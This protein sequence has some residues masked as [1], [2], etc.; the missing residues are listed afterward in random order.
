[1]PLDWLGSI[2]VPTA[3]ILISSGI[4]IWAA[5]VERR[6][7]EAA[8]VRAEAAELIRTLSALGRAAAY[9]DADELNAASARFEQQMSA[10]SALLSRRDGVVAKFI[11]VVSSLA[12]AGPREH[13][14]RTTLWLVTVLE[15]WLRGDLKRRDFARNMPRDTSSWTEHVN[16]A[17]QESIR[18][19]RQVSGFPLELR[20]SER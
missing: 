19:G 15:L 4:A 14:P 5:R 10:F 11:S 8:A 16:L 17:D 6:R 12:D 13:L 18:A 7:S 3:A 9:G 2:A 20:A 1:M